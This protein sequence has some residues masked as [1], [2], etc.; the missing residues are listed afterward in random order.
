MALPAPALLEPGL[1][2]LQM[3]PRAS[4]P[5]WP[6]VPYHRPYLYQPPS[7]S[8]NLTWQDKKLLHTSATG[9]YQAI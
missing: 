1:A 5:F 7:A 3:V 4:R 2:D 8:W 9:P 6:Q